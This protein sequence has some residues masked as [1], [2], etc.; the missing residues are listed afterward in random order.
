MAIRKVLID[1]GGK[2]KKDEDEVKKNDTESVNIGI[3]ENRNNRKRDNEIKNTEEDKKNGEKNNIRVD[4]NND[5]KRDNEVK[6]AEDK[7][8]SEEKIKRNIKPF[9]LIAG[10][11]VVVV[12]VLFGLWI[13]KIN[14]KKEITQITKQ[15]SFNNQRESV[16]KEDL[17][18][19]QNKKQIAEPNES[20]MKKIGIE[21]L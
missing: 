19:N 17:N 8:N 21:D 3:E 1:D 9:P 2:K 20:K 11:V 7:K 18:E 15:H 14:K 5:K 12:V 13:M 16:E 6:D 10:A 4:E